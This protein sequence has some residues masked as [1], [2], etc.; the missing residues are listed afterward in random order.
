MIHSAPEM[1]E[2]RDIIIS[3]HPNK[4]D[5]ITHNSTQIIQGHFNLFNAGIINK[6]NEYE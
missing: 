1:K 4:V 3:K 5:E 6:L 2:I